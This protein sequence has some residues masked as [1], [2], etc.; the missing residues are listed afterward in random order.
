M[1][2]NRRI[3]DRKRLSPKTDVTQINSNLTISRR[4]FDTFGADTPFVEW[5]LL[6]TDVVIRREVGKMNLNGTI[7]GWRIKEK[8]FFIWS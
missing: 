4:Y 6:H 3:D 7:K 2:V 5:N 1:A 8:Y